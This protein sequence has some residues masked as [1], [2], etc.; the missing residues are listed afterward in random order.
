MSL[1][2]DV[3]RVEAVLMTDGWHFVEFWEEE[4]SS[5]RFDAYEF[6]EFEGPLVKGIIPEFRV[7]HSSDD[8]QYFNGAAWDE[9]AGTT[10]YCPV[11]SIIA[12]RTRPRVQHT[13]PSAEG[14]NVSL[15]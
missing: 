4:V 8:P 13:Q 3:D 11:K 6:V 2:I 1:A 10:V 15:T 12:V 5:F 14:E 7:V 9:R